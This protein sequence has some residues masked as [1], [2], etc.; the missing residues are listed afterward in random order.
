MP[1]C[2]TCN[3]IDIRQL[4]VEGLKE[5][6]QSPD[7]NYHSSVWAV[8]DGSKQGCELCSWIWK[9]VEEEINIIRNWS[10]REDNDFSHKLEHGDTGSLV[11]SARGTL[12]LK[13]TVNV[14]WPWSDEIR[15]C[16]K[17]FVYIIFQPFQA[18]GR[19]H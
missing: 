11:L 9:D 8:R 18:V 7:V 19:F 10:T 4:L 17:L 3:A 12:S 16:K 5:G 2:K 13:A 6:W 14:N 15:S 1:L